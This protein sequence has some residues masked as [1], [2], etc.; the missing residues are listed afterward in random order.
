MHYSRS[1]ISSRP[2][3]LLPRLLGAGKAFTPEEVR[4]RLQIDHAADERTAAVHEAAARASIWSSA[5]PD[6]L[7]FDLGRA[8][9]RLPTVVFWFRQGVPAQEIGRRLSPFGGAWDANRALDAAA[10]LIAESLNCER[11]T[12]V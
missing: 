8:A 1:H 7:V 12:H 2:R 5:L 3:P 11:A 4:Q 9:D 6:R 10:S